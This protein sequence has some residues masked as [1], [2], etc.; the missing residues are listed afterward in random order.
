MSAH[1][2]LAS[3]AKPASDPAAPAAKT[4]VLAHGS[5]HG[6]WCWRRVQER[7]VRQGHRVFAVSYTGMGER[8]H[9]LSPDI[10]IDTFV[11]D[12]MGVIEAEELDDVILV[13]HSFGG[14][15]I[16]GVADRAPERL[17]HLVYLDGLVLASGEHSFS[18]LPAHEA[19]HRT[20]AAAAATDGLAVP[21]PSNLPV[22]WGIK[23]GEPDYDW[24]LRRLTPHPLRTYT[25]ALELRAPIGNGVPCTYVE[26]TAP[27]HPMLAESRAL[28]ARLAGWRTVRL[29]APHDAMI[30]HP[31]EVAS[32]LAGL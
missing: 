4:Y 14:V 25:T 2:D 9:L 11:A 16:T 15:P 6:A 23:K 24:V 29:D 21:V 19:E 26:C 30:T 31:D 8:A 32:L 7:L 10:T 27:L 17:R 5:W 22:V 12:L 3:G 18:S 13:G 1:P 20:E 28:V